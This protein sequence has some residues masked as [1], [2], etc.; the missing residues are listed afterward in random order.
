MGN[1]IGNFVGFDGRLGR[2]QWWIS[3]VVLIIVAVALSFILG[4]IMGNGGIL[5]IEQAMDPAVLQRAAWQSLI[6]GVIM[7]YP[8]L[9]ISMKRRHDRNNNGYD[10]AGLIILSLVWTSV[11]LH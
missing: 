10:A 6:V 8:Y 11:T 2:Q 3:V 7:T 1:L 5:T 4:A 9:A